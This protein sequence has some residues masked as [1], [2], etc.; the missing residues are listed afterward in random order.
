LYFRLPSREAQE[1]VEGATL[2]EHLSEVAG[3]EFTAP[4]DPVPMFLAEGRDLP[5]PYGAEEKLRYAV[6]AGRAREASAFVLVTTVAWTG[7]RFGLTTELDLIPLDRTKAAKPSAFHGIVIEQRGGM[8]AEPGS[9]GG[10]PIVAGVPAFVIHQG[11]TL[12]RPGD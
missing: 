9:P 10:A 1:H 11:A 3:L 7:R 4:I 12:M 6:H 2:G 8:G 5:K